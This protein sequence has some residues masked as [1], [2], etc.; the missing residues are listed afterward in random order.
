VSDRSSTAPSADDALTDLYRELRAGAEGTVAARLAVSEAAGSGLSLSSLV[1]V[2]F[3]FGD[4]TAPPEHR[5]LGRRTR[6]AHGGPIVERAVLA[7][8]RAA[9]E[10]A[11]SD[12]GSG[13]ERDS[14]LVR[15]ALSEIVDGARK[16]TDRVE[17]ASGE[18]SMVAMSVRMIS[19][20]MGEVRHGMDEITD[21]VAESQSQAAAA[22]TESDCTHAHIIELT[23][24]VERIG[25]VAG[26]INDIAQRTNLLA[27]N[28]TIEAARAGEA[29][30]GFT[31]VASEVKELANQTAR[32][33]GEISNELTSIRLVAGSVATSVSMVDG[34][35]ATIRTLVEEIASSVAAANATFDTVKS[36]TEEAAD[37]VDDISGVL[38]EVVDYSNVTVNSC[39]ELLDALHISS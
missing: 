11:S 2:V 17:S 16:S 38:E 35:F 20:M 10:A 34:T 23:A 27:L 39:A 19:G 30:R 21:H 9:E 15:D 36:F 3:E 13:V 26:L 24:A 12:T 7:V 25:S 1:A 14:S 4:R 31:V 32:A 28:A 37:A 22:I 29:G 18:A 33:T 5:A 8:L 6:R